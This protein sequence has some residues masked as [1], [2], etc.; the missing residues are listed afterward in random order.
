[1]PNFLL[2]KTGQLLS[3]LYAL[4]I[5]FLSFLFDDEGGEIMLMLLYIEYIDKGGDLK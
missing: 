4:R 5:S 2:A 3:H 1:M